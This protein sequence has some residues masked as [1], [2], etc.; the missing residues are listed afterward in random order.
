LVEKVKRGVL[1]HL[2]LMARFISDG[3]QKS[4]PLA[5]AFIFH[6]DEILDSFLRDNSNY[7]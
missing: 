2:H 7:R 6:N 3:Y 5:V 4:Q 1:A